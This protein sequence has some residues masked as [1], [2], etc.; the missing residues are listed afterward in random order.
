MAIQRISTFSI[1]QQTLHNTGKTQASLADLQKQ[2]SSGYKTDT[3]GGLDGQVEQFS[4]VDATLRKTDTYLNDTEVALGRLGTTQTTIEK[5]I[6]LANDAK[7]LI[8]LRRNPSNAQSLDFVPRMEAFKKTAAGLLN[9][10]FEGRYLFAGTRTDVAPVIDPVPDGGSTANDS[11]YVGSKEDISVRIHNN[12]DLTYNVRADADG[13]QKMF[14]AISAAESASTT[15]TGSDTLL[16]E[17]LDKMNEAIEDINATQ[18]RV[19]SNLVILNTMK[20]QHSNLKGYWKGLKEEIIN[21]DIVGVSTQIATDQAILQGAF[22]SFA[23]INRLKLI[24][25]IR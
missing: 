1:Q 23:T 18:T 22:Q 17:A 6:D 13:F 2:L 14:A 24:D 4:Y 11:Y 15:G 20:D 16:G 9:V 7:N 8:L 19:N 21:T 5:L 25:Y 12:M 10:T 3:Y